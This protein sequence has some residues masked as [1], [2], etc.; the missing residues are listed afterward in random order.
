MSGTVSSESSLSGNR[1]GGKSGWQSSVSLN[2]PMGTM[3]VV[4]ILLFVVI[5]GTATGNLFVVIALVRYRNLRTVS[6]YL[7]GNLAVSD[8]LL[9]TTIFPLSTVNECLGSRCRPSTS[10]SATGCS[11]G[12]RAR[13]G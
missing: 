5:V 6:N 9:A 1:T 8:F 10:V 3:I 12:R 2:Y 7:I 13:S 4:A 11:D